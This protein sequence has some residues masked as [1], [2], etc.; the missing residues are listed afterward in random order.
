MDIIFSY[1]TVLSTCL[2]VKIVLLCLLCLVVVVVPP[3]NIEVEFPPP[4]GYSRAV[5][6]TVEVPKYPSLRDL[7][8]LVIVYIFDIIFIY[9]LTYE[10]AATKKNIIIVLVAA[11]F[12]TFHLIASASWSGIE[13]SWLSA[14]KKFGLWHSPAWSIYY[15]S[16]ILTGVAIGLP[17]LYVIIWGVIIFVD[18]IT[19]NMGKALYQAYAPLIF[20]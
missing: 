6:K 12:L 2:A 3:V 11:T 19:P 14:E 18:A 10:G 4:T 7:I 1:S 17:F 9:P 16:F 20:W 5:R 13:T 15:M 8:F